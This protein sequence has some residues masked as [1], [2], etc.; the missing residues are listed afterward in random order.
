MLFLEDEL[1]KRQVPITFRHFN[2]QTA[3]AKFLSEH[4][5]AEDWIL[6]KGSRFME[7]EHIF[8]YLKENQ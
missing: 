1:R 4:V 3:L 7:M 8:N 6:I 5:K 2:S